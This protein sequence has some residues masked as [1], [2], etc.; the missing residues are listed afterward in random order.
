[1]NRRDT[2]SLPTLPSS[3]VAVHGTNPLPSDQGGKQTPPSAPEP[4]GAWGKCAG[5]A[6][7]ARAEEGILG[8]AESATELQ[9]IGPHGS[10]SVPLGPIFWSFPSV[11]Q[12]P[13][14]TVV[15]I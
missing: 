2:H 15:T 4:R 8:G 12:C 13:Q 11:N 7:A 6:Q 5:P 14:Q 10:S 9:V 3:L 1:M